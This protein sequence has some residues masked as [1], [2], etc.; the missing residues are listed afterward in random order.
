M[1]FFYV[2][3]ILSFYLILCEQ[4]AISI[5][6]MF[7]QFICVCFSEKPL[8]I[9]I[10]YDETVYV[11]DA[12]NLFCQIKNGDKPVVIKWSFRG[13]DDSRG[14]QIVTNRIS[15]STS[16]LSITNASASHSGTYTCTATNSAGSV[17]YS[18]NMTVNGN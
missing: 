15:E 16:L 17:T 9:P 2:L 4:K 10:T 5:C 6:R 13:F 11:G 7:K 8:I 14:I 3:P 18:K 1:F 12:F